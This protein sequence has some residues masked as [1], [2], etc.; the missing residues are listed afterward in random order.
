MEPQSY[1]WG[2]L[3]REQNSEKKRTYLH[4]GGHI[5]RQRSATKIVSDDELNSLPVENIC[6]WIER[7]CCKHNCNY[8]GLLLANCLIGIIG[9][10]REGK[11]R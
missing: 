4:R 11:G 3:L 2:C 10:S 6:F 7:Q 8:V 5:Y 1:S 9:T